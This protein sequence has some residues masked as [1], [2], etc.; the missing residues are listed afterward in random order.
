MAVDA[1]RHHGGGIPPGIP[2][3]AGRSPG[4]FGVAPAVGASGIAIPILL[5][6]ARVPIQPAELKSR[7]RNQDG[8]LGQ[9]S[10][11]MTGL[12]GLRGCG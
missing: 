1:D 10:R 8:N 7:R 5:C 12:S 9:Q 3:D 6:A 4:I 2:S 11:A